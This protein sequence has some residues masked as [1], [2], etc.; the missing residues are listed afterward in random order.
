MQ[1]RITAGII[2]VMGIIRLI[3]PVIAVFGYHKMSGRVVPFRIGITP[4]HLCRRTLCRYKLRILC[5]DIGI[6]NFCRRVSLRDRHLYIIVERVGDIRFKLAGRIG[7]GEII[8]G[9]L[10][11]R[12]A[13]IGR[14]FCQ[15]PSVFRRGSDDE[16]VVLIRDRVRIA[17]GIQCIR[18]GRAPYVPFD[19]NILCLAFHSL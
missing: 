1:I 6:R 9:C 7:R 14:F 16:S 13:V 18:A 10:T 4:I 11:V 15:R 5:L 19:L 2:T 17:H 12:I 8:V 3:C